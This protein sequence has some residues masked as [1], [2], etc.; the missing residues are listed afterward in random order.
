MHAS[1]RR[2]GLLAVII[3]SLAACGHAAAPQHQGAT[4][5]TLSPTS[6]AARVPASFQPAAASFVTPSWGV[7]LGGVACPPKRPCRARLA[8]TADSGAHWRFLTAPDVSLNQVS[9]V[10][11]ASSRNGWLYGGPGLYATHDGG[12]HWSTISLGGPVHAMAAAAGTAYAMVQRR[13]GGQLWRSPAG[14]NAWAR[15][16]TMTGTALGVYGK[17]A[18]FGSATRLW[19]T[20]SGVHWRQYPFACPAGF[21]LGAIAAASSSHVAFSCNQAQGMFH[22][23]K[24]VL[25]SVNG[26]RTAHLTGQARVGGNLYGQF[27]AVPPGLASVITIAAVTPGPSY[28]SRSADSGKTWVSIAIPGTSGGT[29][30]TSLSYASRSVGTVV[31]GSPGPA[32]PHQLL[33]TTDTGLTWH[34]VRF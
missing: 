30:L 25:V 15:A 8:A 29:P 10:M 9:A 22:T 21:E 17:A 14:F 19:A 18:W 32:G 31:V 1:A 5:A 13:A 16:G 11:F 3:V 33:R 34:P 28:L 7:V 4:P 23:V 26:G 6:A 20:T 24:D 2:A 12:A 27:F